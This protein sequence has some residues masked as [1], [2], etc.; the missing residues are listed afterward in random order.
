LCIFFPKN[1]I[2]FGNRRLFFPSLEEVMVREKS[3]SVTD[4]IKALEEE[5]QM[6]VYLDSVSNVRLMAYQDTL[7]FFEDFFKNHPARIHLPDNDLNFF[8]SLFEA[9][10]S[11]TTKKPVHILHYGDSQIESDRITGYFRQK[12]QE[13]FGGN[14]PGLLPIVQ[15]IP[16]FTVEQNASGNLSRYIISGNL[17]NKAGHNR[18]GAMGQ[19]S[20]LA[21]HGTFTIQP[22]K[23]KD[24]FENLQTFSKVRLF[25]CNNSPEFEAGLVSSDQQEPIVRTIQEKSASVKVLTW[26]LSSPVKKITLQLKGYAELTAISLDGKSGVNVD[27]IPLRG[28][29]GTFFT[30]IDANSIT[31]TLKELEVRFI[32]LEFGGNAV[33]AISGEKSVE[34]YKK[35][36]AKQIAWFGK[37]YP[38]AKIMLIGP[39]DMSTKVQGQLQTYPLLP[40]TIEGL[41]AAALENG[42]AFWN[43][44]EV[45]GGENSMIEWVKEK[46]AL[47]SP[48][49]IHFTMNGANKIA[50]LLYKSLMIY[51]DYT[52]FVKRSADKNQ[53]SQEK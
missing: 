42:A 46:P 39:A 8:T 38:N 10:D 6:K 27:N 36:M 20:Q 7:R 12:F 24:A 9:L 37:V 29:S 48:D 19:M 47:A 18:Y 15:S 28:S 35:N 17:A 45:M 31:P 23:S 3:R 52:A 14:G 41:K 4:K 1:G 50:D 16:S 32:M 25:I 33:P 44:Y 26:N 13:K 11:L 21:G 5:F 51:Y 40:K 49:Y 30:E 43:M 2:A 53:Q 34:Y 22:R